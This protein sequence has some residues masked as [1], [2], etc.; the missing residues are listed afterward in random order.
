MICEDDLG[1]VLKAFCR[2]ET[3]FVGRFEYDLLARE[4][5]EDEYPRHAATLALMRLER[6][7]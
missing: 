3:A 2:D 1:A 7:L 6:T 5:R 4:Q